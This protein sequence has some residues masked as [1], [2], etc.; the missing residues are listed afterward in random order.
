MIGQIE[1]DGPVGRG[2][3]LEFMRACQQKMH[4]LAILDQAAQMIEQVIVNLVADRFFV[5]HLE[6]INQEDKFAA[7]QPDFDIIQEAV[8]GKNRVF[9]KIRY[10]GERREIAAFLE[11]AVNGI[12]DIAQKFLN[13]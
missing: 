9:L 11:L 10:S 6:F 3:I 12:G 5:Q 13:G 2:Q 8:E 7:L 4:T 1:K